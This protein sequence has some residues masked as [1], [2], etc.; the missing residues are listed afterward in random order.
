MQSIPILGFFSSIYKCL[1]WETASIGLRPEL[2]LRA[3]GIS[4]RASAKALTAYYSTLEILINC[5]NKK[6]KNNK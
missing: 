1:T 2:S 4:S 5:F 6:K 3:V